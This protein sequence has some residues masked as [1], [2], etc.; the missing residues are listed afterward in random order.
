MSFSPALK[1]EH[2]RRRFGVL[3]RRYNWL[4]WIEWI[5]VGL[6]VSMAI[7][8]Y[9]VLTGGNPGSKLL[10]P[11]LFAV[12]LIA[13]LVPAIALLVLLGRRIAR[14]RAARSPVGG[15]GRLHVRLVALFSVVASI[16]VLLMVIF[17]SLLFQ[18]GVEFWYS[19]RARGMFENA[20]DLAQV[21]YAEK[22]QSVIRRAEVM[23]EDI[24]YNLTLAPIESKDFQASFAYQ[25]LNRELSEGAILS[26]SKA[27]GVQSLVIVNPY[28]RPQ[29]NWVPPDVVASLLKNKATVFRDSGQRMEAVTPIPGR[30]NYYIYASRVADDKALAQTKR[31]ALVLKNYN[32]LVDRSRLLQLQFHA[33]LYL[34][35]LFIIGVVVIIA[36]GVADRLVK[37][38]GE[39]VDAARRVTAGDLTARV[40]TPLPRDEVG[41]LGNAFNRMT[42]RLEA[43]R[44][45][46][47]AAN[48]LLDRRR[49]LTEAVLSGVS[50]GVVA[51]N[52]DRTIRI[53]NSSAAAFLGADRIACIGQPLATIS[54]ELDD[55]LFGL[56]REAIIQITPE[57]EAKTLA[58]K[59]VRDEFGEVITFDD[60]TQQLTDQRRAAWADVAR[61]IAHEIKN[62]L[63]PIQL[64]AERLKRRFMQEITSDPATFGRLTD[65]IVRQVGDLRRMVDEFSS[66]ARMPKPVFREEALIDI[67]RQAVF[68]HEIAHPLIRFGIIAN[69]PSLTLLCDR[70]QLGQ[71]MTNIIKN[72][73]EAIE[74]QGK[75]EGQSISVDLNQTDEGIV[76]ISV[77][78]TGI[79]LPVERDR[80]AEPYMTTRERGTGLGLAIVKK[81]VE[82]HGGTITFSDR[83]GGGSVITL[84]FDPA[85]IAIIADNRE[86]DVIG[87]TSDTIPP[88]L[89]R[90][91]MH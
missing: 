91:G 54:R 59:L 83:D 77:A 6:V 63:T 35:A 7:A 47:V 14:G 51:V 34:I 57:G 74:S 43:Q 40:A 48:E 67:C 86:D 80:L 33:A 50:A 25:V 27:Q 8:S 73:V 24:G 46:L 45:E 65:T 81:I 75:A 16:P 31:F 20:N 11:S 3:A 38:V 58:V 30:P 26:I 21:Y 79:G 62:P 23:A 66:F 71:A 42:G 2:Q 22:Q 84:C 36:L 88:T 61:R 89:T 78:D 18:Y 44:H 82:E 64:A 68:L 52:V 10:T 55:M 37:P 39:L 41:T 1:F 60:I 85:Q 56:E 70:R 69:D 29:D 13:N 53:L 32:S 9:W 15:H 49:A 19:D 87:E 12:L 17:A 72:G 76:R 28:N 5:A 90:I 4:A